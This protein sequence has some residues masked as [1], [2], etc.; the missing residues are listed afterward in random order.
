[1]R[2]ARIIGFAGVA[3]GLTAAAYFA[4][5]PADLRRDAQT[6]VAHGD[7]RAAELDLDSY[8][9]GHP[10]NPL[11]SFQLG[12]VDLAQGNGPSA[13]RNFQVARGGG[14]NAGAL[15]VPLGRAYVLQR[16]FDAALED[17]TIDHA[18]LDAASSVLTVRALAYLGLHRMQEA[19]DAAADALRRDP[20]NEAAGLA[21]AKVDFAVERFAAA[22][23]A[24]ARVLG[25]HPGTPEALLLRADVTLAQGDA[26]GALTQAH[27]AMA[28]IPVRLDAKVAAARALIVLQR[29]DEAIALLEE[30]GRASPHRVDVHYLRAILAVRQQDFATADT[31]LAAISPYI[32]ELKLGPYLLAVTKLARSQPAQAEE[33]ASA[34]ALHNPTDPQAA[35]LLALTELA[36]GKPERAEAALRILVTTGNPDADTL[37]LQARALTQQSHAVDA[38][39]SLARAA[40]LAPRDVDVLNRLAAVRLGLGDTADGADALRLS[41]AVAPDQP[42]AARALVQACLAAGD[43]PCAT[44]AVGRLRLAG[45]ET[46]TTGVLTGQIA[47]ATLDNAGARH[48]YEAVL[49]QF[50]ASRA[51]TFGLIDLDRVT[52]D[53]AAARAQLATWMQTHPADRDGLV[54][55]IAE[56]FGAGDV[57]G[58]TVLAEAAHTADPADRQFIE[59]LAGLY[60][61][62]HQPQL[63]VAL[64]D[65]ALN[66][67]ADAGDSNLLD[68]QADAQARNGDQDEAKRLFLQAADAQPKNPGPRLGL[69]ALY[70]R[71]HEFDSARAVVKDALAAN[72][73]D[74][75]LL[76]AAV[77]VE[78]RAAGLSAAL[79]KAASLCADPA[80]LPGAWA[81]AGDVLSASGD[82]P[83]AA[84]AYGAAFRQ[85]PS[86]ALAIDTT[87][88]LARAGH[89]AASI[90]LLTAWV[91]RHPED[92]PAL[93]VLASLEI[94]AH[95]IDDAGRRLDQVL[96]LRQNN[97]MALNNAAWVKLEQGDVAAARRLAQR[98]YIIAP[99]PATQDTLG[100]AIARQGDNAAALPLLQQAAAVKPNQAVLYHTAFVLQAVGRTEEA[101]AAVD[102]ALSDPKGFDERGAAQKLQK[103]LQ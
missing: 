44:G 72:P 85:A 14:Y 38:A 33:A 73:G 89:P 39:K 10:H 31:A 21:A 77:A 46:E 34:Y 102:R 2:R 18:P 70:L 23:A 11:A 9:K 58:A 63:A 62:N 55:A 71:A 97:V 49:R 37:D 57:T 64:L 100:W 93:Q 87:I 19:Q 60:L 25:K 78:Q 91:A 65:R 76:N 66:R 28:Q 86:G 67:A 80:N 69:V 7:L 81:L 47:A 20:N 98:A 84:A 54:L 15:I 13:E 90:D 79:A 32:D 6:N 43:M 27:E 51:A 95:R 16:H 45:G 17:F 83:G 59:T 99:G 26:A 53:T 56:R 41:L 42:N 94:T 8:L 48:A 3:A 12:M 40:V 96:A 30:V 22:Q 75:R 92:V 5:H 82:L 101:R 61:Q 1:M 24:L 35:K 29:D 68:L 103:Q 88:A 74:A 50:P 4:L 52:G 36:I